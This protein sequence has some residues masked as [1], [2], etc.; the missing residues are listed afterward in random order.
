MPPAPPARIEP[1]AA[2]AE[3]HK[4][5]TSVIAAGFVGLILA[6]A[7]GVY[8]LATKL[9]GN[10][11]VQAPVA[12]PAPPPVVAATPAVVAPTPDACVTIVNAGSVLCGA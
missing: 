1:K 4:S 12:T 5:N 3:A 2:A 6:V 10:K 11:T 8:F 7:G 9:D